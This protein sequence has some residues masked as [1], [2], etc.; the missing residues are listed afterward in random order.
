MMDEQKTRGVSK[1]TGG[2]LFGRGSLKALTISIALALGVVPIQALAQEAPVRISIPAQSL[3]NALIQLG[4]QASLQIF[5]L[6]ETVSGLNAPAV[7]GNLTPD[8]ALQRLLAGTGIEFKRNGNSVSLS[9][10]ASGGTALLTPITVRGS[11]DATTE[12]TDSYAAQAV[13]IGKGVQT[14]RE[15]PQSVSVITRQQMDDQGFTTVAEALNQVT[16]ISLANYDRQENFVARGYP[17]STQFNGVPQMLG[18]FKTHYDLALY[19]RIEV[20]RGPSGLLT[21]NG[22]PGGSVNY[23]RK[24]PTSDFRISGALSAGSWDN[25]RA[26]LDVGGPLNAS[27]SLR[28]R[29]VAVTQ[30]QKKFWDLG[31]DKNQLF[32]GVLEYDLTP[33]TTVDLSAILARRDYVN[34]WGLPTYSDGTL[35]GRRAFV[36]A[37]DMSHVDQKEI[38]V[39]FEHRFANGWN[40]EA[41]YNHRESNTD[42]VLVYATTPIDSITGLADASAGYL[43]NDW[44]TDNFD[45]NMSGPI[46]LFGQEHNLTLGYNQARMDNITG[47]NYKPATGWDVLNNHDYSSVLQRDINNRSQT[48]TTQSGVYGSARI[49]LLDPLTLILGGRFS[50][51]ETKSRS[52]EP[53]TTPWATSLA[54]ANGEFTPYGGLVWDINEQAS[55]YTSYTD[56]FSPQ[57]Q[58]DYSGKVLDPRTGS[59]IEVG[60]KGEFFGGKLNASIAAFRIR[61]KNRLMLDPDHIGCGGI[62]TGVC[63]RAAGEVES[64]GWELEVTG[65]PTPNWDLALGY[66][67]VRAKYLSDS[68]PAN[69]GQRFG[70]DLTPAHLFKLWS[71]YRFGSETLDGALNGWSVGVGVRAQSDLYN[72][73]ATH[74]GGYAIASAKI[75]Y[76]FNK[77]WDASLMIDNLFDRE[78]LVVPGL[79]TFY[80]QYGE[81][82]N[83][84]LTLRGKF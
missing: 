77:N 5:Y 53:S 28:G 48:L 79:A 2:G 25:Y 66:T 19:D 67:Y 23:V 59:Q 63:Y 64:Q 6:P 78:Y 80:S 61:D 18:S 40:A 21:G 8:Q 45:I 10:P 47:S 1:A 83:F 33:S 57:A 75:D 39:G 4:E 41:S 50:N 24:R 30:D 73:T 51:Y 55:I 44:K 35:P 60:A 70:A 37:D 58:T 36:G 54:K 31:K 14:L 42:Y 27:G 7:T 74:Q 56:I 46:K 16:G 84:M 22:D 29:A 13:T 76:R 82:R 52:I 38:N 32:F 49:K 12:G 26:E 15:I 69:V 43:V 34:N 72:G 11:L 65:R 62:S 3:G 9:K 81:P 17:T 20:L 71:Q 68:N